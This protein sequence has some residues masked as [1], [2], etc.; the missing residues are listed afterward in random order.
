[1]GKFVAKRKLRN[2]YS[3]KN[4]QI[5]GLYSKNIVK[6]RI[7]DG[8]NNLKS[9]KV[10]K[11]QATNEISKYKQKIITKLSIQTISVIA[12]F[13]LI[14]SVKTLDIKILKN[15]KLSNIMQNEFN[16]NYT[17]NE[18]KDYI[19][20]SASKV[21][22]TISPI[23]PDALSQ[24]TVA[25]FSNVLDN[26]KKYGSGEVEIY[27]EVD[28]YQEKMS[29]LDGITLEVMTTNI[30]EEND[31]S[32]IL[33]S[34]VTFVKPTI[35]VIT[36]NYGEREEIFKGNGT[37]HNGVDIA[38]YKGTKVVASTD[39]IVKTCSENGAYGKYVEIENGDILTRYCHLDKIMTKAGSSI[40]AGEK[41]GEMGMTGQATGYHLHFEILYEEKRVNPE[42]ILSLE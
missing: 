19:S 40:S 14:F 21:Y 17:A 34:G 33:N 4:S 13:I 7:K 8:S 25:V 30:T 28:I 12:I 11:N 3:Q 41:I 15:S 1:M 27:K 29:S 20:T 5:N 37:F 18:I 23:I 16:K 42:Q 35:G 2:N 6:S 38:N 22:V 9:E 10:S 26:I 39:G 32:K 31:V 24:K 36:S